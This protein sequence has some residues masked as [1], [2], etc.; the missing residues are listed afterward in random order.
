MDIIN[1]GSLLGQPGGAW[2]ELQEKSNEPI[3]R[4]KTHESLP[5]FLPEIRRLNSK[6]S[7][8]TQPRSA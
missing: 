2:K 5:Y 1:S 4:T 3:D 8:I 7:R 6:V